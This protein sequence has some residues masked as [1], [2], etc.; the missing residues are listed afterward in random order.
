MNEFKI[1]I[2]DDSNENRQVLATTLLNE[3]PFDITLVIDGE[4]ALEYLE[5]ERPDLILLDIMMPGL[6]GYEVADILKA[7]KSNIPILFITAVTE[8]DSVIRAFDAGATDYITKPFRRQELLARVKAQVERKKMFDELTIKNE[9]LENKKLLLTGMVNE[10]T[11]KIEEMTI[12]LITSLENANLLNDND[13]GEHI[14]RVGEYARLLAEEYTGDAEFTRNIKLFTSL[15]D[16]GKVGLSDKILKKPGKYTPEEFEEMKA[17]V[18]L[19]AKMLDSPAIPV[20]AKNI[21]LYHH[22][23]WDGSGYAGGIAGEDIPLEARIVALADVYDALST[24]RVY[25][26]A[27]EEEIIDRIIREE[28]GRHFEPRL[29][30]IYFDLKERFLKVKDSGGS[31]M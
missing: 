31:E 14:R 11:R 26:K 3:G 8:L 6:S 7:R 17:H 10:K 20:M 9:L 15:H 4:S 22:E 2:V 27:F 28:R 5:D 13:T 19:G 29:V 30:D 1:L 25:K 16:V 12:A 18:L 21:A 23:K 24:K